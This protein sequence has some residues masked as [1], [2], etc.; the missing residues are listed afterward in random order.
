MLK[1]QGEISGKIC[2]YLP[3]PLPTD[4][5]TEIFLQITN[6][7]DLSNISQVCKLWHTIINSRQF[8]DKL[9]IP[10]TGIA[11]EWQSNS[12]AIKYFKLASFFRKFEPYIPW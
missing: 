8:I 11:K 2:V 5:W 10:Y 6:P 3:S 1:I 7:T 12:E 4:I 9:L